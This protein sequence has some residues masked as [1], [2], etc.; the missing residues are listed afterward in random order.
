MKITRI[1]GFAGE[2]TKKYTKYKFYYDGD[3]ISVLSG[4]PYSTIPI[5]SF[6]I[7]HL[8]LLQWLA[9]YLSP[10]LYFNSKLNSRI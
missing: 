8:L 3:E 5:K 6:R 2:E 7:T 1:L 9:S 10:P 4:D